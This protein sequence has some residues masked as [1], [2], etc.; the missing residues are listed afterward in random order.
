MQDC[1]L[2]LGEQHHFPLQPLELGR[3]GSSRKLNRDRG[4][5]RPF[6]H[7]TG[8]AVLPVVAFELAQAKIESPGF[9]LSKALRFRDLFQSCSRKV[10]T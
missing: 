2:V 9:H 1:L 5:V 3:V 4:E 8:Q 6:R 10:L 7:Q